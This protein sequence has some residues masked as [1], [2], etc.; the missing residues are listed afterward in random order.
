V[1]I[2]VCCEKQVLPRVDQ[3]FYARLDTNPTS[4]V[5]VL[6]LEGTLH[7]PLFIMASEI[8]QPLLGALQASLTIV[9]DVFYGVLAAQF[10][11]LDENSTE[12]ISE[13]LVKM[14]LP[15]LMFTRIGSEVQIAS[16]TRYIPIASEYKRNRAA[17][18]TP[19]TMPI[20][21]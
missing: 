8:W 20:L 1:S 7:H 10:G 4:L 9:L 11:L 18:T 15:A 16:A 3:G 17:R 14:F 12:A 2:T 13:A 21:C 6:S 5:G 19:Q